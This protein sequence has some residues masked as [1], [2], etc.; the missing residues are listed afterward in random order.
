LRQYALVGID[1]LLSESVGTEDIIVDDE[2]KARLNELEPGAVGDDNTVHNM[3]YSKLYERVKKLRIEIDISVG[4]KEADAAKEA[5]LTAALA[6]VTQNSDP[7]N[8]ADQQFKNEIMQEYRKNVLPDE[9]SSE[10][11][12]VNNQP[13]QGPEMPQVPTAQMPQMPNMT[14]VFPPG[15]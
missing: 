7:N 10:P 12:P 13:P 6:N 5:N 14:G 3:S 11:L 2:T 8:P 4:K 9:T 1:T 15:Q